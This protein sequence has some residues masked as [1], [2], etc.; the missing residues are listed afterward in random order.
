MDI[1]VLN[2]DNENISSISGIVIANIAV[3]LTLLWKY[4]H[5]LLFFKLGLILNS[6]KL[7]DTTQN[8]KYTQPHYLTLMF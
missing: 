2:I 3:K 1:S 4:K 8:I 6:P 7:K 5:E